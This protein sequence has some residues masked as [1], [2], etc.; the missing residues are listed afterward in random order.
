MTLTGQQR[1]RT[2]ARLTFTVLTVPVIAFA[3]L[4][5][6]VVPVL[7]T[8]QAA[9]H[10]TQNNVSWV[11]TSYLLSASVLTP[12]L[13]PTVHGSMAWTMLLGFFAFTLV[14][15]WLLVHRYRLETLEERL[16]TE[17]LSVALA[18]R[19]AEAVEDAVALEDG[20]DVPGDEPVV[21][22]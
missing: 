8:I 18:E 5:S 12:N 16:E 6:L 15:A 1:N 19:R 10:T 7:P 3:L 4:Q 14:Y 11:V 20:A 2:D 13:Q 17:G 21:S 9:L 22:R